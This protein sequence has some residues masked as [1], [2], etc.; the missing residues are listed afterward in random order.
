M[1]QKS[2]SAPVRVKIE[3]VRFHLEE[4]EDRNEMLVRY[5]PTFQKKIEKKATFK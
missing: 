3:S 4:G 2:V 1:E 5:F